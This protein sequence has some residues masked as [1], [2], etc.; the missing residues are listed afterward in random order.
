MDMSTKSE[1]AITKLTADVVIIGSGA[2]GLMAAVEAVDAGA[3]TII[4]ESEDQTGG[5][6][7]LS[8]AYVAFC[9]TPLQPG[10]KDELLH[11]L[12]ESHHHD[13]RKD[14]SEVYVAESARTYRRLHDLGIKFVRT[15]QFAHMSKPWA[16]E[17]SGDTMGGGA[18]IVACLEAAALQRGVHILT[19]T[20]AERFDVRDGI[21]CGIMAA[22]SDGFVCLNANRAIVIASGG[23]TRSPEL[24]SA[25]GRPGC[26][27]IVPL[28]GQGSRGDG[29][30][31]GMSVGANLS[32]IGVGVA[33]TS[34]TNPETGKGV[35]VI[36]AG[37]IALNLDGQRFCRESDVY[38]DVCW[39][40]LGQ[41][42]ATF[43][44]VFDQSMRDRYAD[45]MMGKVLTGFREI[46]ANTLEELAGKMESEFGVDGGR[47]LESIH[48][49]NSFV[50]KGS[51][52]DF[53]RTN[54][55]GTAGDLSQICSAPFYAT[56]CVPGTTHFNGGLAI[57]ASMRVLDVFGEP[58][59]RLFA[60]GEV[61]GGFHGAGYMS[62]TFVGFS[63]ISGSVAG[64]V[65]AQEE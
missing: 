39:A 59:P 40:A 4:I 44:Q 34:P 8:G 18:E 52:L 7:R 22:G 27:R 53:G 60:A 62:G 41:R 30:K 55:I 47:A 14:L 13:S 28:T 25:F 21:P 57:D 61:T 64:R 50:A 37:A 48:R 26:D 29:L 17:L 51:D 46:Q 23:F 12:D 42:E 43:V 3:S 49:Y 38:V 2:A 32:Y 6:T 9:E 33:P 58:I 11:D 20:R 56:L 54:I 19:A 45:S 36:Y 31:L 1:T 16:H 63:L 65:A 5:S 35:M 15:F 24:I 10:G